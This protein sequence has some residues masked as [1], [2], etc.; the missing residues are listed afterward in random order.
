MQLS[1]VMAI[2]ISDI[3]ADIKKAQAFLSYKPDAEHIFLGDL[4]DSRDPKVT[5]EEELACLELILDSDATLIWGNHDLACTQL[6]PWGTFTRFQILPQELTNQYK[7]SSDY[8]RSC[9]QETG[10]D[11]CAVQLFIDRIQT[12]FDRF[13][14]ARAVDGWLCTHAG[15]SKAVTKEL[16]DCPMDSGDPAKVAAYL[17]EEFLCECRKDKRPKGDSPLE[18]GVGPLFSVSQTRGGSDKYGGIFWY[19][20]R[21]E[22]VRP[23]PRVKQ[24]FGH[25][26]I[27]GPLKQETWVNIN[28]ECG[29]WIFDTEA[30]DFVLLK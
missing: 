8:L 26:P 4:I 25:T 27:E 17:N 2:I 12:H 10:G 22:L 24:I 23:D 6:R 11:L 29:C 28:I 15:L 18:Y 30:D 7:D 13:K 21:R 9:Y 14:V 20:H 3:H 5:F 1:C 19:D 16:P